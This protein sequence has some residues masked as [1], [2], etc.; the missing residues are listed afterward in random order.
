MVGATSPTQRTDLATLQ[1]AV[2]RRLERMIR[3]NRSRAEYLGRFER[4][5]EDYNAGSRT[6]EDLFQ[7]L[8]GLSQSLDDEAVRHV[9]EHLSE[10]ELTIFDLL[11]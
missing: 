5:L 3:L 2:R 1:Q 8:L 11:T 10:E 9:R 4:L 7:E 6:I